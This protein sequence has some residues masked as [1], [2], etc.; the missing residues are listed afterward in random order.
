LTTIQEK[1]PVAD[2]DAR[3]SRLEEI[4]AILVMLGLAGAALSL[5]LPEA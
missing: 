4:Y 3:R 2:R 5:W 1:P